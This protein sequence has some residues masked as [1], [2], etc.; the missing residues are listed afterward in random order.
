MLAHSDRVTLLLSN[1]SWNNTWVNLRNFFTVPPEAFQKSRTFT[2][3]WMILLDVKYLSLMV[4]IDTRVYLRATLNTH[5]YLE[6]W[7]LPV[8]CGDMGHDPGDVTGMEWERAGEE[9]PND[10]V[11]NWWLVAGDSTGRPRE[12][13][14]DGAKLWGAAGEGCR[15]AESWAAVIQ[16]QRDVCASHRRTWPH[17]KRRRFVLT[18]SKPF[19]RFEFKRGSWG[20]CINW[21]QSS[22][23]ISKNTVLSICFFCLFILWPR[24][25]FLRWIRPSEYFRIF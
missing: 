3:D 23:F 6:P 15:R 12:P 17:L 19:P 22:C 25:R 4:R 2:R 24:L 9:P 5:L 8:Y 13:A 21:F 18:E 10:G 7:P 16:K 1:R 20:T 14:G 11:T